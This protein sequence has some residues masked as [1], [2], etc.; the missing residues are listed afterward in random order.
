MDIY[1]EMLRSVLCFS[2]I[3]FVVSLKHSFAAI[4]E[5]FFEQL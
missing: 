5:L 4:A 3:L 2:W 1:I